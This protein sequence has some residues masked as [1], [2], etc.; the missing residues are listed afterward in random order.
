MILMHVTLVRSRCR[1]TYNGQNVLQQQ[2]RAHGLALW[3]PAN[4]FFVPFVSGAQQKPS[5]SCVFYRAHVKAKTHGK[6]LDC[7]V[8][9]SLSAQ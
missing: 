3:S 5:L 2:V 1:Q 8:V 9:F 4:L 7:R 6:G